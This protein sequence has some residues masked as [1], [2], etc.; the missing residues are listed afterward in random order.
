MELLPTISCSTALMVCT[1][2]VRLSIIIRDG[3]GSQAATNLP[4]IAGCGTVDSGRRTTE[5]E[6][7]TADNGPRTNN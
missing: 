2:S 1:P 4:E 6:Q 3:L 7:R 5:D